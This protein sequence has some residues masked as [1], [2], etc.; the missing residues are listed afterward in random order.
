[1]SKAAWRSAA[2]RTPSSARGIGLRH[3]ISENLT[4]ARNYLREAQKEPDLSW[5]FSDLAEYDR[6]LRLY[7]SKS[8]VSARVLEIGYGARPYR[9]I[10]LLSLGTDAWGVDAEVPILRGSMR[11]YL[12]A[13]RTNGLE[14]VV[15]SLV[16]RTLFDRAER[17]AFRAEVERR[18]G[19]LRID[20]GRFLVS[21]AAALDLETGSF[22]LVISEDTF[23]HIAAPSL[24]ALLPKM[25]RWLKS[26]GVALIRPNIFTGITGGHL[27]EWSRGSLSDYSGRRK[28]DPWEHL[29]EDRYPPDTFLNRF[30][31]ADYRR[32]FRRHFEI[33]EENVTLPNLGRE[34]FTGDVARELAR[35]PEEELFSNQVR[36]VLRPLPEGTR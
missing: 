28:S 6:L 22:E 31:R 34:F 30:T 2:S 3:K 15:K 1:V 27:R 12:A 19:T 18:A 32:M 26:D 10:A 33:L 36:F 4:L 9:L 5:I 35:F 24:E 21:D 29:R 7:S 17:V 13:L 23:E 11:E 16:R 25:A 14:R 8:L 20:A